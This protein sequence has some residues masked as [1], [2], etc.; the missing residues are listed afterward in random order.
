MPVKKRQNYTLK[1]QQEILFSAHS[2]IKKKT[3]HPTGDHRLEVKRNPRTLLKFSFPAVGN[4]QL[5]R[6][7]LAKQICA[8]K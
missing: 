4:I 5:L 7:I 3:K 6:K 1:I 8:K 2:N